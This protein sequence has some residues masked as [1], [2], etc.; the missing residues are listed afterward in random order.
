ME[1]EIENT[2]ERLGSTYRVQI[3]GEWR[4]KRQKISV[5]LLHTYIP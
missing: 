1:I 5:E 3:S 4:R 2:R